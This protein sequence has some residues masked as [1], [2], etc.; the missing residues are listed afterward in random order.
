MN[1]LEKDLL[2]YSNYCLH[3]SN[4]LNSISKTSLNNKILYICIDD[5]KIKI[6][7]F[8]TRVPSIFLVNEKNVLVEDEIDMW[9]DKKLF[10]E[11]QK[12]RMNQA[13]PQMNNNMNE[14]PSPQLNMP[15]QQMNE[16]NMQNHGDNRN[17]SLPVPERNI[18]SL[19]QNQQ[20]NNTE[21]VEDIMAYH[22]NEMGSSMSDKY[23]FIED[24]M[25]SSLNHNFSFLDGSKVDSR[26]NT[27]KEFNKDD[28][29]KKSKSENDFD[30]LLQ[31]RNSENFSKGIQRI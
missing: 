18:P 4:L 21:V 17:T 26:I 5:K 13:T 9:L 31:E 27:P 19:S 10:V 29:T 7:S 24:D 25:N 16:P 23:S 1:R 20:K 6:P 15:N 12:Q 2:F 22:G 8:I 28:N 3:S 11:K 30:R 14:M